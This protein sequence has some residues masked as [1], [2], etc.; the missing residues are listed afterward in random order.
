MKFFGGL[1]K[2]ILKFG[3]ALAALAAVAEL[4][5]LGRER[6]KNRYIVS[7]DLDDDD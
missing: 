1:V 4:C 6:Y 3:L 2:W 7:V 5:S